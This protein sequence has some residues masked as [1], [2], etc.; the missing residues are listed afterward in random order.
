MAEENQKLLRE[1]LG[2]YGYQSLQLSIRKQEGKRQQYSMSF[3][4]A[5]TQH[6]VIG[7]QIIEGAFDATLFEAFVFKLL[8][9][10]R[11]DPKTATRTAI[12]FMDNAVVHRHSS[13]LET[14][15]RLKVNV[16]FNAE[17]SPWLNPVEQLFG[18]VKGQLKK[19][20]V[21]NK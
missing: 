13:V 20:P 3:I 12:L 21:S 7:S 11:S 6:E 2:E 1:R 15:R 19:K 5:I 9:Q 16:I 18:Y 14:C 10:I 4:A 8:N 17:Y